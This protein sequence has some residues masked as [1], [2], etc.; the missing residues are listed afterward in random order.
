MI[1]D[2]H[3]IETRE[4][5]LISREQAVA[6]ADQL[7]A[8]AK[9][10]GKKPTKISRQAHS[11]VA[12]ILTLAILPNSLAH[13]HLEIPAWVVAFAGL[14][15]VFTLAIKYYQWLTPL[16]KID[17]SHFVSYGYAP[18][19]K[20]KIPLNQIVTVAILPSHRFWQFGR[21][22]TLQLEDGECNLWLPSGFPSNLP[23]IRA[24][25][26]ENFPGKYVEKRGFE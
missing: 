23:K 9:P 4:S 21:L 8:D 13:A 7:I 3:C 26:R 22:L 11:W 20:R 17:H 12:V 1:I 6:L 10:V 15:I 24:L 25:L 2:I 5:A 18:W 19:G 14:L 16:A